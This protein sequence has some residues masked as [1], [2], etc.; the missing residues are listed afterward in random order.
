MCWIQTLSPGGLYSAVRAGGCAT[1]TGFASR[2]GAQANHALTF[3]PRHSLGAD[4]VWRSEVR[5]RRAVS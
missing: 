5:L 2:A 3:N 4:Q 1:P